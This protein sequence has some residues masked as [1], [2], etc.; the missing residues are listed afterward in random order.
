[1]EWIIKLALL[2]APL[3]ITNSSAMLFGGRTP[4]DFGRKFLDQKPL[5]GKGKT[6]KGTLLGFIAGMLAIVI[7]DYFL[8]DFT[9]ILTSDYLW[10]GFLVCAGAILGDIAESFIKRRLNLKPGHDL[11][12]LDQLDFLVGALILTAHIYL[13]SILE[14]AAIVILT[15]IV[16][17][18]ANFIAFKIKLKNVPW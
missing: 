12:F 3:Y 13:P 16:H 2:V 7:I 11:W 1:M 9:V 4:L 5:L 18:S 6:I 8:H 14:L 10:Y 15:L 17:R